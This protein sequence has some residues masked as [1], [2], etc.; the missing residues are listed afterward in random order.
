MAAALAED[1]FTVRQFVEALDGR[2]LCDER[3][4]RRALADAAGL[5][6][7]Q[8]V[9]LVVNLGV[10]PDVAESW[11]ADAGL[12]RAGEG[13]L[14]LAREVAGVWA[15]LPGR[16]RPPVRL[17]SFA[18]TCTRDAHA[19]D[20]DQP[21]G[22][23]TARLVAAHAGLPRPGSGGREWRSAWAAAGVLCDEVSSRVLVLNLPLRGDAAAARLCTAV[24]GEPT[25]LTLRSLAGGWSV[26]PGTAVHI[27]ENVTV[28]EA[29][30]D[31]LG[32]R[33][34]PLV[35]T[36]GVPSFAALDLVAGLDATG[37]RITV[38]ADVDA[39]GFVV[40]DQIRR[41]APSST[42]WRFDV[43]TY[44]LHCSLAEAPVN[45]LEDAEQLRNLFWQHQVPLHEESVLDE[46]LVDLGAVRDEADD[47]R[48]T[49][50][51]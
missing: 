47:P 16:N 6:R 43:A 5:E 8:V 2:P 36:D 12:P 9:E 27:C 34:P 45:D 29:A 38:R 40:V 3:A 44:T 11:V 37:A 42:T 7:A 20:H 23:A 31:L 19:L 41:V 32:P 13:L 17:A 28:A 46:L 25:W 30:A 35:C 33:C 10:S 21:L 15:R 51:L 39:G 4:A 14:A 24:P 26:D 48:A 1:G 49:R 22:R 50:S 18:S